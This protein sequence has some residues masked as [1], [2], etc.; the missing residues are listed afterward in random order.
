MTASLCR[1]CGHKLPKTDA[2]KWYCK[3]CRDKRVELGITTTPKRVSGSI[4]NA[5]VNAGIL[6]RLKGSKIQCVDC[7]ELARDYD[8]RDYMKPLDVEPVCRVCNIKRGSALNN[9]PIYL[10]E[11]LGIHDFLAS[12]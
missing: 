11:K 5:A 3:R 12:Q 10:I 9:D 1:I 8:H 4:V 7:G 2:R 6:P